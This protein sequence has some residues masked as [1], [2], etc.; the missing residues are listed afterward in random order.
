M[1]S[2]MKSGSSYRFKPVVVPEPQLEGSNVKRQM[3]NVKWKAKLAPPPPCSQ[4]SIV[5]F[6]VLVH[7]EIPPTAESYEKN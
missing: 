1:K 5:R 6:L 4:V 3:I 2:S 7:F